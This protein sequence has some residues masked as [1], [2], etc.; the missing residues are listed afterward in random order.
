MTNEELAV[1]IQEGKTEYYPL[2]W[3][4]TERLLYV[5]MQR[6]KSKLQ[7][8]F[9]SVGY[10]DEDIMQELY[11]TLPK[12]VKSFDN[13]KD[14]KFTTYLKYFVS[15]CIFNIVGFN[16]KED[17][18]NKSVSFDSLVSDNPED[19]TFL[20]LIEDESAEEEFCKVEDSIYYSELRKILFEIMKT[21]L[22]PA[23]LKRIQEYY[24]NNKTIVKISE[25]EDC[26]SSAVSFSIRH[27][28]KKIQ[29]SPE[30]ERLK[31]YCDFDLYNGNGYKAFKNRGCSTVEMVAESVRLY[32]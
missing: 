28:V 18:L 4:Q 25:E 15:N 23:E 16:R 12:A 29:E 6:Y 27:G 22:S 20:D 9:D 24:F 31:M 14:C 19:G 26:S 32:G 5:Y 2:L 30:A 7:Y 8:R 11:F 10:T 21:T 1:K 3:E 17:L 13:T